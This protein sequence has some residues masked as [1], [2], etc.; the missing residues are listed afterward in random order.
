MTRR[1]I[2]VASALSLLLPATA[3]GQEPGVSY[4]PDSPAGKEYAVPLD[5][6]RQ[7]SSGTQ[8]QDASPGATPLFGVGVSRAPTSSRSGTA[9]PSTGG[10]SAGDGNESPAPAGGSGSGG[11]GGTTATEA[12]AASASRQLFAGGGI[13]ALGV[14]LAVAVG[15]VVRRRTRQSATEA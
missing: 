8:S 13:A 14:V 7:E 11:G 4:D 6:V 5:R 2:V 15:F 3:T 10:S 12:V 9:K 1:L